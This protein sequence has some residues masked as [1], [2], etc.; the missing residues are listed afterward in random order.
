MNNSANRWN[1]TSK[2]KWSKSKINSPPATPCPAIPASPF[3]Q[4]W[5]KAPPNPE[6][7][8]RVPDSIVFTLAMQHLMS[9]QSSFNDSAALNLGMWIPN[10]TNR[11]DSFFSI[12]W[13]HV[14]MGDLKSIKLKI[15]SGKAENEESKN[16]QSWSPL[17]SQVVTGFAHC[18][19]LWRIMPKKPFL[20]LAVAITNRWGYICH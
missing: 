9:P 6:K 2:W 4:C 16:E 12:N 3:A 17:G 7:E 18:L 11:W 8:W 13:I 14:K 10:L 1:I 20:D 19:S 5:G 15:A